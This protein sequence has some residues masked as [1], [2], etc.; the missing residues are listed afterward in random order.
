MRLGLYIFFLKKKL[1]FI[2]FES[3]MDYKALTLMLFIK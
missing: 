1:Q 3:I 2:L